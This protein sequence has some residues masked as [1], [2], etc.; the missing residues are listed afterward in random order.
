MCCTWSTLIHKKKKKFV[1]LL[2]NRVL[3]MVYTA[4]NKKKNFEYMDEKTLH[5][6]Q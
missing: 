2:F 6:K 4:S 1:A 3:Y 5:G